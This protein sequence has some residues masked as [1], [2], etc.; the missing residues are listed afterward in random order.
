V[1]RLYL[2]TDRAAIPGGDLVRAVER[3]LAGA[4]RDAVAVQLREKD[5]EGRELLRLAAAL[6]AVTRAAGAPLL[7][8]DRVD[9]AL[10]AE[11]DGVHL[12]GGGLPV[13]EARRLL[14]AA[15]LIGT[16]AHSAAAAR[17]AAEAGADFVVFGPVFATPSKARYGPP[18]GLAAL[19]DACRAAGRVPVLAI[20]GIEPDRVRPCISAGAAGVAVIRSGLGAVE[21]AAAV[22]ALLDRL[23]GNE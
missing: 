21:P 12:P 5:L 6:R 2:V 18:Q 14:G 7:V 8:N 19:G 10:A 23:G 9:V 20:G 4:P 1:F 22:A 16:S 3:A 13:A 15:R 11:A 17:A